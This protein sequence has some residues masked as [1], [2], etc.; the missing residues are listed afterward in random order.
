[1]KKNLVKGYIYV[2]L[3]AVIFGTMPLMAKNIYSQGVTPLSL[4]FFRNIL[5]L[6]MLA[7]ASLV[8][9]QSLKTDFKILPSISVI[10]FMGCAVTPVLLFT[11]YKFIPSG[12]A[13]VFHFVYPAVVVLLEIIF[14]KTKIKTLN[15]ISVLMCVV[16]ICMFYNPGE[17]ISFWGSFIAVLSGVTYA[18]YIL[19]LSKFKNKEV[20]GFVFS[21]YVALVASV[22]LFILSVFAKQ[23][24]LP[25]SIKGWF[26]CVVFA[27]AINVCAVVLF[28]RGT[29]LIGGQRAS[30]LSTFEPIV[31]VLIGVVI[32]NESIAVQT[33]FG[34]VLVIT[35]SVLTAISDK[36]TQKE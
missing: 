20:S 31:S 25:V 11:S 1:M 15:V 22:V 34:T 4:V 2:I 6:P 10:A 12:V 16:G 30:I 9:K 24:T 7:I 36:K 18:I 14:L 28:Q 26:L 17:S 29:F 33:A 27:F 32:F 19:L 21:F 5:S 13:T 3:S 8:S 35:A 23:L